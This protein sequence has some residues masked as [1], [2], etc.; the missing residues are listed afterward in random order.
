M[1]KEKTKP[2]TEQR[3]PVAV[4][5]LVRIVSQHIAGRGCECAAYGESECGCG[6]DWRSR[7]EVA[8]KAA[9]EYCLKRLKS[10]HTT[11]PG[12]TALIRNTETILQAGEYV[13]NSGGEVA[14]DKPR[15]KQL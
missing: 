5:R 15:D 8:A 2:K 6:V 9:L 12:I 14:A 3:S 11:K 13:P 4:N 1:A 10:H 7:E